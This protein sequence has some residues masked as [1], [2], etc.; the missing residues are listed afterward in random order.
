M[1]DGDVI[2]GR[3]RAVQGRGAPFDHRRGQGSMFNNQGGHGR[4]EG[5][6]RAGRGGP[7]PLDAEAGCGGRGRG[8]GVPKPA[9]SDAAATVVGVAGGSS[10]DP[11]QGGG[12]RPLGGGRD[13]LEIDSS[14]IKEGS[15]NTLEEEQGKQKRKR[16]DQ[17]VKLECTICTEKHYTNQCPQLRGPKPTVAYYGAADEGNGFF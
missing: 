1:A 15:R 7:S 8:R 2:R 13:D 11:G 10:S 12:R 5:H 16:K 4:D 9:S 14:T 3:G 17:S 6:G